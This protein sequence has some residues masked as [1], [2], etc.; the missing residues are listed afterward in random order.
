M[1]I[2]QTFVLLFIAW[3][4]YWPIALLYILSDNRVDIVK[5]MMADMAHRKANVS[6]V[7]AVL[8]VFMLDGY[9]RTLFYHRIGKFSYLV[10]WIYRCKTNFYV[11]C[12]NIR[13]GY[14]AFIHSQQYSMPVQLVQISVVGK[15]QL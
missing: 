10:R 11:Q 2:I 15:T 13:G 4:F 3:L 12:P 6:G 8:Y 7:N 5:D 9:Y 1:K 14:F